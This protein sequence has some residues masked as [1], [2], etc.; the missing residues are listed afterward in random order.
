M[1]LHKKTV[2]YS[3]RPTHAAR[4]AHAKGDR[5][6]RT[7]DT[8]AIMPKRDPKPV[9]FLGVFALIVLAA[10]CF[11]AFKACSGTELLQ[12]GETVEVTI[13]EGESATSIGDALAAARLIGSAQEFTNE[14]T[15]L[16]AAAALIPPLIAP[17]KPCSLTPSSAPFARFEP[18]PIIGIVTPEPANSFIYSNAPVT[19][20]TTPTSI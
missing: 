19:S 1:A 9:I 17:R 16:D 11:F 13:A 7:Y 18:K 6:F 12:P 4:A 2:T 10:V 14:V 8:S 15:R 20:S 3:S 5:E